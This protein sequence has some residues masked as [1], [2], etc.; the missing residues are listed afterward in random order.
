MYQLTCKPLVLALAALSLTAMGP[1]TALA[2]DHPEE[3]HDQNAQEHHDDNRSDPVEKYR[4]D[5]PHSSAR[6]HDGFFT[7]T[8]DRG[9]ACSKHGGI[10]VWLA[11]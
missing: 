2:Q 5:H 1:I 8:K 7:T 3:H 4:H 6:C 11:P 9:R 10:D